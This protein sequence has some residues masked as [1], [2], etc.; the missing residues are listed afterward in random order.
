MGAFDRY[1]NRPDQRVERSYPM[2]V[3]TNAPAWFAVFAALAVL[4]G[5]L[6]YHPRVTTTPTQR[7]S[8]PLVNPAPPPEPAKP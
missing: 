7:A 4:I 2:S 8:P 3:R 5:V 6:A 1:I